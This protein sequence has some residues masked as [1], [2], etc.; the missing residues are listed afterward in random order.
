MSERKKILWLVSWYPNKYD[1]FDGD[2]IQRHAQAAALYDDI[3]VLFIRQSEEQTKLEQAKCKT[4]GLLEQIIYLPKQKGALGKLA[5]FRRWKASYKQ[6]VTLII[7]QQKPDFIHVH[8]P[9]KAGLIA[10]WAKK[11]FGIPYFV[12]EHWGIYNNIVEDNI[13]T[14]SPVVRSLLKSIFRGAKVFISVSAY[15]GNGVNK[16]L[17]RTSYEVIPNVVNTDLFHL[18]AKKHERFTFVHV[19]NMVAL[20]NVEGILSAFAAFLQK[21]GA[22]AQLILIGNRDTNHVK[23]AER[24]GLLDSAVFFKGEVPYQEVAKEMQQ[25]HVF[26]LNSNIENSPCV[27]GEALCCGLP[28]IATNVGGIPELVNAQSGI[29]VEPG[30][31]AMLASAMEDIFSRCPSFDSSVISQ[32]ARQKFSYQQVGQQFHTIY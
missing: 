9:W 16:T 10:L 22:N 13:Y 11:K 7:R 18:S 3:H 26:V 21:A 15:L 31:T 17:C 1:P 24:L 25:S 5:N 2:F 23:L 28:V 27:I 14:K 20:K 29:L 6:Q 8:I 4:K 32:E 30:N 12:T 19:S